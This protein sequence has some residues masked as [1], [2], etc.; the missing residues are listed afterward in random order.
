MNLSTSFQ[1]YTGSGKFIGDSCSGC[2]TPLPPENY[3]AKIKSG[4]DFNLLRLC[5]ECLEF[6]ILPSAPGVQ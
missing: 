2:F 3:I 5:A 6:L 1:I 4:Q